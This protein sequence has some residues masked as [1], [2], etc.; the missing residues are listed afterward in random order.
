[1]IS[2][3]CQFFALRFDS[4]EFKQA[5][6]WRAVGAPTVIGFSIGATVLNF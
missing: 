2:G 6:T 1:V 5:V 4:V 3:F